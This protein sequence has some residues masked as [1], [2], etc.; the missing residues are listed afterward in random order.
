M[1]LST[2]RGKTGGQ[3]SVRTN[4]I[5][6]TLSQMFGFE[7]NC[8]PFWLSYK[9]GLYALQYAYTQPSMRE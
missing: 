8:S 9:T 6:F 5:L 1:L 3:Q 2:E 7:L 4:N